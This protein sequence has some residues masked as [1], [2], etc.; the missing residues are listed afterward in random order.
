MQFQFS[1]WRE[2]GKEIPESSRD[3]TSEPLKTGGISDLPLLKILLAICQKSW[4]ASFWEV[5]QL[6]EPRFAAITSLLVLYFRFIDSEDL[7]VAANKKCDFYELWQQQK[8]LKTMEMSEA[9]PNTYNEGY[10]HQ[11]QPEPIYKIY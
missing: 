8:Q 5:W 6:Q 2:T 7:A 11:F 3:N 1:S 9:W 4:E 10:I